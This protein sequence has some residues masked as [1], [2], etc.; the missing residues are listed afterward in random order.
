M[1]RNGPRLRRFETWRASKRRESW[2]RRH[3]HV[4]SQP[5]QTIDR[6]C[7]LA[8][9]CWR[10]PP[11]PAPPGA[12]GP[13]TP[14]PA[15]PR[16]RL[17]PARCRKTSSAS[18]RAAPRRSNWMTNLDTMDNFNAWAKQGEQQ[19]PPPLRRDR[20]LEGGADRLPVR[21]DVV[22]HVPH[23]PDGGRHLLDPV[24]EQREV[25]QRLRDPVSDLQRAHRLG[26]RRRSLLGCE[27]TRSRP[28]QRDPPLQPGHHLSQDD[29]RPLY[30]GRGH[31]TGAGGPHL[32]LHPDLFL[33]VPA[34]RSPPSHRP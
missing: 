9:C 12:P 22:E 21:R 1:A 29:L 17:I 15:T 3:H 16:T 11:W 27:A 33:Q 14:R 19:P 20:A 26:R 31:G 34:R 30:P 4:D 2:Q 32:R 24:A 8:G 5:F 23:L 7:R 13:R 6:G 25:L 28:R 18:C 10:P